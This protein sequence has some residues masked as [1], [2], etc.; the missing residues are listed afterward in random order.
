MGGCGFPPLV[1]LLLKC[2]LMILLLAMTYLCALM[3]ACSCHAQRTICKYP[4]KLPVAEC[5]LIS[6][7][8][9]NTFIILCV[10]LSN[11]SAA[12]CLT[13]AAIPA[14]LPVGALVLV[15]AALCPAF[16]AAAAWAGVL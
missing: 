15:D 3:P 7:P 1:L 13:C 11:I 4:K 6:I 9:S 14:V 8:D 10:G 2:L 5:I 16:L 12:T